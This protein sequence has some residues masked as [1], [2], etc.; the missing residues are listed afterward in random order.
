MQVK[1]NY[2]RPGKGVSVHL[3][4]LVTDDGRRLITYKRLAGEAGQSLT[5]A[6][7]RLGWIDP[8]DTIT[9]IRKHYFYGEHFDVLEFFKAG[10]RV[11]GYYSDITTPLERVDGEYFVTDLFLDF[12]LAPGKPALEL[13]EDEFAAAVAGGLLTG[14]QQ[15]QAL[16]AFERLRADIAAGIYPWQ[17]IR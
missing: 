12:W 13:D 17:Y 5:A 10:G 16:Q 11:A 3:E 6:L 4:D 14:E 15:A 8:A 7:V 9:A 1:V 2:L